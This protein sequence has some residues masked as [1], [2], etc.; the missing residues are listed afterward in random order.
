VRRPG[1]DHWEELSWDDAIAGIA[2]HLKSTRDA[3]FVAKNAQGQ[4]VNR[5]PG[6]GLIGGCTDTNEFNFLQWKAGASWGVVYRDT[7]ARV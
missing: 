7:Q 1:S 4:V 5:N 6:M 3:T 2:R